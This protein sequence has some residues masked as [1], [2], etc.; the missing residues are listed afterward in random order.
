MFGFKQV[1]SLCWMFRMRSRLLIK[2]EHMIPMY[3]YVD[4]NLPFCNITS[5]ENAHN[6]FLQPDNDTRAS[7]IIEDDVAKLSMTC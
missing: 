3:E 2:T 4:A 7:F 1:T 6:N 5:F